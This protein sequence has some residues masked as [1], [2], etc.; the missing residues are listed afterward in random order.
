MGCQLLQPVCS[1]KTLL[2]VSGSVRAVQHQLCL[3]GSR[4]ACQE[5]EVACFQPSGSEAGVWTCCVY[6]LMQDMRHTG[7]KGTVR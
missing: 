4:D 1:L 6:Q 2:Q 3:P 5:Y 7:S